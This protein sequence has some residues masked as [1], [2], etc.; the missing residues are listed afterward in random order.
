MNIPDQAIPSIKRFRYKMGN[1]ASTPAAPSINRITGIPIV[2]AVKANSSLPQQQRGPILLVSLLAPDALS[3]Q[4]NARYFHVAVVHPRGIEMF[5]PITGE[6]RVLKYT[7]PNQARI[8]GAVMCQES[9]LGKVIVI[10]ESTGL[11]RA[12]DVYTMKQIQ[13]FGPRQA[14]PGLVAERNRITCMVSPA[15]ELLYV[16]YLN[17]LI[18]AWHFQ[19]EEPQFVFNKEGDLPSVRSLAYSHKHR[20]LL[21]GH[22]STY[23]NQHGRVFKLSSN[24]IRVYP[25]NAREEDPKPREILGLTGT[26]FGLS[27]IESKNLCI[28]LSSEQNKV[29]I[30]DFITGYAILNFSIPEV[31]PRPT[32]VTSLYTIDSKSISDMVLFGLSDGSTLVSLLHFNQHSNEFSWRPMKII[33]NKEDGSIAHE[34]ARQITHINYESSVDILLIGNAE[35]TCTLVNNFLGECYPASS[36]HVED[37]V[38]DLESQPTKDT[39][40]T[41]ETEEP[42]KLTPF[43]KFL[44][45]HREQLKAENP[46]GGNK[47]LVLR[48]TKMWRELSEE[49]RQEYE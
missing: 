5:C 7:P 27:L 14:L 21:S 48:A 35:A 20:L 12:I 15:P 34:S 45:K 49:A 39:R 40:E 9:V 32:I 23:E 33:L 42:K 11:F 41:K 36:E 47:D 43:E 1:L 13:E 37:L 10:G 19:S 44:N 22:E 4:D 31:T 30:W 3:P 17:G 25:A 8:V 2:S 26:C 16:G 29:H 24:P 38:E 28:A 6:E 18:K 46:E